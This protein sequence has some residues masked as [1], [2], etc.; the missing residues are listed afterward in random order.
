MVC[1]VAVQCIHPSKKNQ[2]NFHAEQTTIYNDEES[3]WDDGSLASE[4]EQERLEFS[5]EGKPFVISLCK[6]EGESSVENLTPKDDNHSTDSSFKCYKHR[7]KPKGENFE[8]HFPRGK[9]DD[10]SSFLST[11]PSA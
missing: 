7:S 5:E 1:T 10:S 11:S 8:E 3:Q 2:L 6:V 9:S 4:T